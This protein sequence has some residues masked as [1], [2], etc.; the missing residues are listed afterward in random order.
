MQL[1]TRLNKVV[2]MELSSIE[3]PISFYGIS[4]N[5]GNNYLHLKINYSTSENPDKF[6]DACKTIVIPDGNY[7]ETDLIDTLNYMITNPLMF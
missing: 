1:P 3:L 6:S 7:T 4:Q 2:S 5:Y